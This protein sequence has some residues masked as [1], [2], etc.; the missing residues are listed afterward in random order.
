MSNIDEHASSSQHDVLSE[1]LIEGVNRAP[2]YERIFSSLEQ[3][4]HWMLA[5]SWLTLGCCF[6]QRRGDV[7]CWP[8]LFD[9]EGVLLNKNLRPRHICYTVMTTSI[10]LWRKRKG[11]VISWIPDEP[12]PVGRKAWLERLEYYKGWR[13]GVFSNEHL[14]EPALWM[15]FEGQEYAYLILS[16]PGVELFGL[17]TCDDD[18]YCRLDKAA[19]RLTGT[20][21]TIPPVVDAFRRW[22]A[23]FQGK[24]VTGRPRGSDLFGGSQQDFLQVVGAAVHALRVRG[25]R[26]SQEAVADYLDAND[27]PGCSERLLRRKLREYGFTSWQDL[28]DALDTAE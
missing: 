2:F 3:Q 26:P 11:G 10:E 22:W 7:P 18:R 9:P 4:R 17:T 13:G 16:A 28:L 12:F 23:Q 14:A 19:F 15:P 25:K 5:N 6:N 24:P 27:L 21:P 1:T 20:A 8:L